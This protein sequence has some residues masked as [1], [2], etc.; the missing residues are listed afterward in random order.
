MKPLNVGLLGAG[1]VGGGVFNVLSRNHVE[2][3]R[4]AGRDIQ[5]TMVADINTARANEIVQ[6]R[7]QIVNDAYTVINSPDIDVVIE[8]IGGYGIAKELVLAAIAKGKHVVT[9]N[10]ALIA[11]HG[12]EIFAAAKAKGVIVAFEAVSYTHLTLPT[13][14]IV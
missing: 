2:I 7:A 12:N 6:G 8:L 11:V 10:K 14:R 4:R 1:T 13:K 5:I 3:E 9:A